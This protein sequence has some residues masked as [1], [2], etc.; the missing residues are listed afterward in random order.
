MIDVTEQNAWLLH[1][2][3]VGELTQF[4]F[5][6]QIAQTYLTKFGTL[7]KT[8]GR[9]PSYSTKGE[10]RVLDDIHFDGIQHCLVETQENKR[11][12]DREGC[13]KRPFNQ[14]SKCDVILCLACNLSFHPNEDVF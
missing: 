9:L 12:C 5:K 10:K 13:Q 11:R 6:K 1:K 8:A 14:S 3:C 4:E 2:K 7:P